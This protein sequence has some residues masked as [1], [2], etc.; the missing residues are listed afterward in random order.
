MSDNAPY[1]L[2]GVMSNPTKPILR[3]HWRKWASRFHELERSVRV[4]YIFGKTMYEHGAD[5]GS[6]RVEKLLEKQKDHLL[7][8]S[9]EKLPHVGLVTEKSAYFWR[10]AAASEPA[11]KWYCKC[12]DEREQDSKPRPSR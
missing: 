6:V 5:E 7:V 3:T 10:T 11:A 8:D 12:D 2:L 4:R 1:L 9:R